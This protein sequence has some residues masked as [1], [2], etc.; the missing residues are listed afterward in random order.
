VTTGD[1][2]RARDRVGE[3]ARVGV[4]EEKQ[5][6]VSA[7]LV[8]SGERLRRSGS[9]GG[10]AIARRAFGDADADRDRSG[11]G[12]RGAAAFERPRG[13]DRVASSHAC[14]RHAGSGFARLPGRLVG[15]PGRGEEQD[16][17]GLLLELRDRLLDRGLSGATSNR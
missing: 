12:D 5:D 9:P 1:L 13:R 4:D 2:V 6:G 7:A 11:K 8:Q 14:D 10:A 16:E 15:I 17:T 3:V